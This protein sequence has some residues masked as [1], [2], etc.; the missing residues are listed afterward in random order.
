MTIFCLVSQYDCNYI[1]SY[2]IAK[3]VL[4]QIILDGNMRKNKNKKFFKKIIARI[5]VEIGIAI[6]MSCF[7]EFQKAWM[8]TVNVCRKAYKHY[9]ELNT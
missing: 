6:E 8:L 9:F 3:Y 2:C 5:F 1:Q 7:N 4:N